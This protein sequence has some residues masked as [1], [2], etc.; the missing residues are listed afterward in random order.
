MLLYDVTII[1]NLFHIFFFLKSCAEPVCLPKPSKKFNE[2]K[3][4]NL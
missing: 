3:A 1:S 4:K 2:K